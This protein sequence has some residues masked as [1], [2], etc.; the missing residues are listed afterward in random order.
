MRNLEQY[1]VDA[2][3]VIERIDGVLHILRTS[4]AAGDTSPMIL[5]AVRRYLI[6]NPRAV[7]SIVESLRV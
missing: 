4:G 6:D 3:E 7:A 2:S 5:E 1:P